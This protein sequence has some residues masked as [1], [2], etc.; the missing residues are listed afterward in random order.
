[1]TIAEP[2]TMKP[3]FQNPYLWLHLSGLAT[4]P[5]WLVVLRVALSLGNP[6]VSPELEVGLVAA[7]GGAPVFW[8]QVARPFYIYSVVL[9]ALKPAN[10]TVE[11]R[12][13][14]HLMLQQPRLPLASLTF[15]V[16]IG[17]LWWEAQAAPVEIGL[18]LPD[19]RWLGLGIACIAF[20]GLNLFSQIPIWV[21]AVLLSEPPSGNPPPLSVAQVNRAFFRLGIPVQRL[22]PVLLFDSEPTSEPLEPISDPATEE[23]ADSTPLDLDQDQPWNEPETISPETM[24]KD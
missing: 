23:Q 6:G 13:H 9:L 20:L 19:R 4:V 22:L 7:I 11:Q 18:P 21:A 12:Q 15:S 1:M 5:L 24:S 16:L 14:L 8:M 2:L 17:L 3:A 10:L